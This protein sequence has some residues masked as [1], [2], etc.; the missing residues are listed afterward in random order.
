[1]KNMSKI[2]TKHDSCHLEIP[3]YEKI[4]KFCTR[5]CNSLLH[6]SR[7]CWGFLKSLF[8]I[9]SLALE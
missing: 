1:M 2:N 3:V 6:P 4:V 5:V 7:I 9:V 8:L